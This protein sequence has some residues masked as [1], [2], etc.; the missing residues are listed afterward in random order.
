MTAYLSLALGAVSAV[1]AACSSLPEVQVPREVRVQVPVPC[2]RPEVRPQRPAL[3]TEAELLALDRYR[4]TLAAWADLRRLESYAAELEAVVEGCARLA[5][6]AN[7][8]H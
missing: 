3:R 8:G 6:E 4:R 1:L 5:P 2:I 7:G